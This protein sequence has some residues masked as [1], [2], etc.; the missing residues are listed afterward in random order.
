[1]KQ[2]LGTSARVGVGLIVS[3]LCLWLAVRQVPL[4]ELLDTLGH[5]SYGWLVPV[6]IGHVM[7]FLP[8][9]YRWRVLLKNRGGVAEYA[10]AQATGTLLNNVF[11]SRAGEA[12]RVVIISRRV[13]LPLVHV[14]ASVV[15]ERAADMI[16]VL[17]LLSTLLLI[18]DVPW[19]I[20]ATGLALAITLLVA[21]L[22][23]LVLTLFGQGF[24]PCVQ[25]LSER[26]PARCSR[27]T[28]TAWAQLLVALEPIRDL[29]VL[30]QVA[31]WS[32]VIWIMG[33]A[34]FW[35]AIEAVAPGARLIEAAFVVAATSIGISLPSSPG[36]IGVFQLVGQQ[37][38]VTPFP[39][40]FTPTSALAAVLL[41]HVLSYVTSTTVGA[42]G[43]VRLGLSLK[44]V[45]A[46]AVASSSAEP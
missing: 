6:V 44:T 9:G 34:M 19:P 33:I 25:K 26:L 15:F 30:G 7:V 5:V 35:A 8:R 17:V 22:G 12:G 39:D 14:G 3:V 29:R 13:N 23:I 10:L 41:L 46:T 18:M 24:S 2:S 21:I 1:M 38:L 45:R 36:F 42:L 11:P 37:A 20:T 28:I 4:T 40:R 32:A 31:F 16:V 43:L 27:F